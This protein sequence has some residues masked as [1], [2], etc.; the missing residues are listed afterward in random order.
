MTGN[1]SIAGEAASGV[2]DTVIDPSRYL[3]A[4]GVPAQLEG[5]HLAGG[6]LEGRFAD[7]VDDLRR[8]VGAVIPPAAP[9]RLPRARPRQYRHV[10][11][12]IREEAVAIDVEAA[13]RDAHAAHEVRLA[14]PDQRLQRSL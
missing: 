13:R 10:P 11:L 1:V 7:A 4:A 12:Q 5:L 8:D 9:E 6:D 2:A 3:L 14:L